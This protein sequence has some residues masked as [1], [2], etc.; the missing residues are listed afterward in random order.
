MCCQ[1][2]GIT[3][4]LP[5]ETETYLK[6]SIDLNTINVG[7]SNIIITIYYYNLHL[8]EIGK[9]VTDNSSWYGNYFDLISLWILKGKYGL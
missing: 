3:I 7:I 1:I 5:P 6:S 2:M 8:K 4:V 9:Y